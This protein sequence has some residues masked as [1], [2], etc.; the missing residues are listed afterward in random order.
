MPKVSII[1]PVYNTEQDL[2]RCIDSIL[3]QTFTDFELIL[4]NDG[5]TDNSG[6]ICDEYAQKDSRIIVLHKKN[7]GVSSARNLGIKASSGEYITFVDSDDMIPS[8]YLLNFS[9]ESD[10]GICGIRLF[11]ANEL[12]I[13]PNEKRIESSEIIQFIIKEYDKLYFSTIAAKIFKS[14]IIFQNN[15]E[16]DTKLKFGED[17]HF[18]YNY[19][20]LCNNISLHSQNLYYYYVPNNVSKK[21][22]LSAEE[23][24][25]HIKQLAEVISKIETKY[26]KTFTFLIERINNIY[27]MSFYEFI[28]SLQYSQFKKE[29]LR[30]KRYNL[31]DYCRYLSKKEYLYLKF[32]SLF[33]FLHVLLKKIKWL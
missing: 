24:Y 20:L 4:V 15:L 30:F 5:S 25:F 7:E 29:M 16:F 2:P 27:L 8:S 19:L 18:V 10:F 33:P 23:Y 22:S 14:N 32:I 9:L 31:I 26:T 21:Y 28:N 11:G 3:A 17:T 6:A 12:T 1:V 13:S